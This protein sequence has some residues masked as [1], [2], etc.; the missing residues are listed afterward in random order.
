MDRNLATT[1]TPPSQPPRNFPTVAGDEDLTPQEQLAVIDQVAF[2]VEYFYVNLSMKIV[3]Q[4]VDPLQR[5]KE[6]RSRVGQV[7]PGDFH[8]EML[9]IVLGLRD[10]HTRYF[11]P[12]K[13]YRDGDGRS[14]VA[15]LG[16][17]LEEY[18]DGSQPRYMASRVDAAAVPR[19]FAD[20]VLVTHWNGIPIAQAVERQPQRQPGANAEACH[21]LGVE[22]MAARP[23]WTSL[24]PS[25]RSVVI[26]YQTA[27]GEDRTVELPWYAVPLPDD[28]IEG[29]FACGRAS[30][31]RPD[32]DLRLIQKLNLERF[33]RREVLPRSDEPLVPVRLRRPGLGMRRGSLTCSAG[34]AARTARV[35][36]YPPLQF[37]NEDGRRHKVN[38]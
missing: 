25:E 3:S 10:R 21:A 30:R 5:L 12:S 14:L 2:L 17:R 34:T 13:Y 20:G 29:Q 11:L 38:G 31:G 33:S 9:S 28:V 6:L 37:R 26:R 24:P 8:E 18:I 22:S 15:T 32:K 23:L 16:F 19:E 1:S 35:R 4:S 7:G 36:R 27:A